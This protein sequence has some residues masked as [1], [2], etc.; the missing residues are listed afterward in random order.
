[1]GARPGRDILPWERDLERDLLSWER[2]A[3]I[4]ETLGHKVLTYI[5][6]RAV[7]VIFRTIDPPPPLHPASVSSLRAGGGGGS[8][9]RKTPDIGFAYYSIIPLRVRA[10]TVLI[11]TSTVELNVYGFR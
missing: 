2:T 10:V 1:M 5:E 3:S 8:I 4:A 7:S 6:Y 11:S 9:F